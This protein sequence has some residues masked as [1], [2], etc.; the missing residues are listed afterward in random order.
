MPTLKQLIQRSTVLYPKSRYMAHQW[1][2][3]SFH[4]YDTGAHILQTGKF[5]KKH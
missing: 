4:L 5:F 2:R 1:V 3:K